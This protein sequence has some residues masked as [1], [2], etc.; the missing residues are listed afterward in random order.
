MQRSSDFVP[1]PAI[2]SPEELLALAHSL[3]R[4]AAR[5]YGQLAERMRAQGEAALAT[6]F[7]SLGRIE[8]V[9]ALDIDGSAVT[10]TG[11]IAHDPQP[12]WPLPE[13]FGEEDA[14]SA[15]LSRYR[16]LV[17]AVRHKDRM[18]AYYTYVAA[19]AVNPELRGLAERLARGELEQAAL[20]R[21]ERRRAFRAEPR[22]TAS[23]PPLSLPHLLNEAA[24]LEQSTAVALRALSERLR[25]NGEHAAAA[26]FEQAAQDNQKSCDELIGRMPS[27]TP[28]GPG[29][30]Q[31]AGSVRGGLRILEN[32]LERYSEIADRASDEAILREAQLLAQRALRRLALVRGGLGNSA[33]RNA[34]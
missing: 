5:R 28:P 3:A 29:R 33:S 2:R 1:P 10:T 25:R 16:A 12:A 17:V 11:R 34:A 4:E 26:L 32:A 8:D 20:L 7:A 22:A 31:D 30:Q 6:L 19:A 14:S 21:R 13:I 18:F 27:Q 15:R 23:P 24:G 9:H